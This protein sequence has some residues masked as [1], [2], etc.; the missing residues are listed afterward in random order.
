MMNFLEERSRMRDDDFDHA[1]RLSAF[2]ASNAVLP[3]AYHPA[4]M[5]SRDREHANVNPKS[6]GER[7]CPAENYP[8]NAVPPRLLPFGERWFVRDQ[9]Q[10]LEVAIQNG[11]VKAS[12]R[13]FGWRLKSRSVE[14]SIAVDS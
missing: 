13:R 14:Q 9:H 10:C 8:A 5:G 3:R 11:R 12:E 4:G 2:S 7:T 6:G 1:F